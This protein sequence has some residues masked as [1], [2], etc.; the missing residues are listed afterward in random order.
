MSIIAEALKKAQQSS[1]K[2]VAAAEIPPSSES[3]ENF[4]TEI[5]DIL[6]PIKL[7]LLGGVLLLIVF[8][9]FLFFRSNQPVKS[10]AKELAETPQEE[11]TPPAHIAKV[12][13][14]S[15]QKKGSEPTF[16]TPIT[17][18]EVNNS[19][20][21]NGIMYTPKKPLAVINGSIWGIGD[22]IGKFRIVDIAQAYIK[23]SAKEQEFIVKLKR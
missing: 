9:G 5:I 12:R 10:K 22:Y 3:G 21:L 14:P 8:L 2:K 19:I 23:V 20:K 7:V 16:E 15:K 18:S 17:L 1:K 13:K 4:L 6:K 11:T